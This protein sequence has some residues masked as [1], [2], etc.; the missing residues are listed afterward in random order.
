MNPSSVCRHLSTQHGTKNDQIACLECYA[1]L[2]VQSYRNY[3]YIENVQIWPGF[4]ISR[5]LQ[6]K[7]TCIM[8]RVALTL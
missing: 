7:L 2:L 6:I 1:I 4:V 8:L 3:K 5:C